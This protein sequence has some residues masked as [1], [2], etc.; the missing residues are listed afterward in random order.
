MNLDQERSEHPRGYYACLVIAL[1]PILIILMLPVFITGPD[2]L[3][4]ALVMIAFV[5]LPLLSCG[6]QVRGRPLFQFH[7]HGTPF[8]EEVMNLAEDESPR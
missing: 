3:P 5:I 4:Y 2:Q 6:R 1:L 7:Y 8:E